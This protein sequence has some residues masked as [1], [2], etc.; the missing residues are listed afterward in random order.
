[1]SILCLRFAPAREFSG[2]KPKQAPRGS[3]QSV[4][5]RIR[6]LVSVALLA[7]VAWRTDWAH[8]AEAFAHLQVWLW[9]AALGLFVLTQVVSGLRWQLLARP[10]G[11][12]RPL[13]QFV[14]I[15]YIG[16]YF[17]LLLPTSVGGDV[18]RA[19]YLHGGNGRRTPAFVTVLVDRLSGLMVLLTL[20]CGAA[21]FCPIHLEPWVRASVWGAAG[22]ALLGAAVLP[23]LARWTGRFDRVRR[24]IEATQMYRRRPWLLLGTTALSVVVQ[25]AN[26]VI[27]WLIG[28]A[29]QAPVPGAYYWIV[30]PMVSLLTL[31][32]I[33]VN[34]MGIREGGMVLFLN[35][36]GV[37]EGTALTLAFLWFTVFTAASLCG[38]AVYLFGRFGQPGRLAPMTSEVSDNGFVRGDSHQGRA[39]EHHAAA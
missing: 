24:L 3:G 35:P 22:C 23:L 36:L 20:A 2:A 39:R 15:T 14:G 5:K 37:N 34:G 25:V 6:L 28:E 7:V 18:V 13:R 1:M 17:N 11:F 29:I 33:S 31:L 26:V 12:Q 30:V 4:N 10:L 32:P 19:W 27:V 38:G 9:L 21:L 16:M 8:V